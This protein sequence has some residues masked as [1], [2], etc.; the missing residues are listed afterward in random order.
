MKTVQKPLEDM[1]KEMY[2]ETD[3]VYPYL[4]RNTEK[5][6]GVSQT[7]R[8]KKAFLVNVNKLIRWYKETW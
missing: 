2:S 4:R 7:G 3:S 1:L 8:Q 5:R 6:L